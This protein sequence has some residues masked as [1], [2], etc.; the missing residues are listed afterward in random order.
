[1]PEAKV[2]VKIGSFSFCG[3]GDEKW[4]ATQLDKVLD[5]APGILTIV[6]PEPTRNANGGG[7]GGGG[8]SRSKSAGPLAAFLKSAKVGGNQTKLYLATAEWLHLQ[9]KDHLRTAD[10]TKAISDNKQGKLGNPA[11]CLVN[12]VSAGYCVR[13]GKDFYVSPQGRQSLGVN[14]EE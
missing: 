2:E 4:V 7:S 9:G 8:S 3:E 5:R 13:E 1:M 11:Q 10:V 6:P 14:A 12:N